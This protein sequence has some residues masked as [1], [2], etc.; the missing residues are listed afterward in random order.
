MNEVHIDN[1]LSHIYTGDVF[2]KV[3]K[4]Q[5]TQEYKDIVIVC[6][7]TDRC[8]GDSLGPLTGYKLENKLKTFRNTYLYGTLNHPVHAKNLKETLDLIRKTHKY[9]FIIAID[10]CLGNKNKIGNIKISDGPL[11]PGA[12]V[13]K[14]L[15]P[16]GNINILGIV[17]LCGFMELMVLQSTRLSLVM[18]MSDVIAKG[19]E[20]GLWKFNKDINSNQL[21]EPMLM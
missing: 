12:G 8:T 10:A 18:K 16:V 19:I 14:D 6:I 1:S 3:L 17:N 7:G 15:P 2:Y 21:K 9:P 4:S 5:Y 20:F 13:H 11:K